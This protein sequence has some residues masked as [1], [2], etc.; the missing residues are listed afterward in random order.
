MGHYDEQREQHEA[1]SALK[2]T[3]EVGFHLA[4]AVNELKAALSLMPKNTNKYGLLNHLVELTKLVKGE[5]L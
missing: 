1:G 4:N 3:A 5:E 2:Q